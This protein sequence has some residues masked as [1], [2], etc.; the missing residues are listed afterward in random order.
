MTMKYKL[1]YA[2]GDDPNL[3]KTFS[4]YEDRNRAVDNLQQWRSYD[5]D[6]A[7][8]RKWRID[9]QSPTGPIAEMLEFRKDLTT[10][11]WSLK[12]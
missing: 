10:K 12:D 11:V 5:R 9:I 1:Q 8:V 3:W 4:F 6:H 7:I 2:Y